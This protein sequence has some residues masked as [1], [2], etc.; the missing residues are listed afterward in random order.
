MVTT[1][2][3]PRPGSTQSGIGIISG[4]AC[5]ASRVDIVIDD[6]HQLQAVYGTGREDT[7]SVCNDTNNGLA[8]LVNWNLLPKGTHTLAVVIDGSEVANVLFT[9]TNLGVQFL[10]GV[11]GGC[12]VADFPQPGKTTNVRWDEG[13]QRFGIVGVE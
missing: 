13:V 7:R 10:T 6:I 1:L 5:R 2:E 12:S 4:W 9:V 3:N 8:L 11:S